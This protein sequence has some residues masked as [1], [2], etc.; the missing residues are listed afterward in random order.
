MKT[1]RFTS[2]LWDMLLGF[3]LLTVAFPTIGAYRGMLQRN[4]EWGLFGLKGLGAAGP[5]WLIALVAIG[6]WLTLTFAHLR[7]GR[8]AAAALCVWHGS[9]FANLGIHAWRQGPDMTLRGDAVGVSIHLALLGPA[10]AGLLFAASAVHLARKWTGTAAP[11]T[12]NPFAWPANLLLGG[13]LVLTPV[14]AALFVQGDGLRHT[15]Y[16]RGAILGVV[17]QCL[18][19]GAGLKSASGVEGAAVVA[20]AGSAAAEERP[21][22]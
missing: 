6:G 21:A 16:D 15:A 22:R 1:T 19:L 20:V 2:V 8:V 10:L 5:W 13:G 12:G 3:T 17:I 11:R 7:P 4:Y 9:L 18:L 14:I